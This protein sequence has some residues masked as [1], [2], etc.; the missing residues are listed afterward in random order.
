MHLE[1]M[2]RLVEKGDLLAV[3]W[4][5]LCVRLMPLPSAGVLLLLTC[6]R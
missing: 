6:L 1:L 5:S 2:S 3:L 4:Y